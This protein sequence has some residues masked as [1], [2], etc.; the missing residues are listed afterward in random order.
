MAETYNLIEVLAHIQALYTHKALTYNPATGLIELDQALYAHLGLPAP[1]TS[2]QKAKINLARA[3]TL[4][5][6]YQKL[7]PAKILSGGRPVRQGPGAITKKLVIFMNK[8]SKVTDDEILDAT[9]RYIATKAKDNYSF[10]SCS[11]YFIDKNGNSLLE[12]FITNPDLGAK[13]V[14][15]QQTKTGNL[16]QRFV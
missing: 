6:I 3:K 1:T 8:Y 12:A 9:K 13:E 16:N 7:W 5:P 4:A 14:N 10:I 15:Q 2:T 11:D